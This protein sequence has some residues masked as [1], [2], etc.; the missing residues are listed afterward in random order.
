MWRCVR[1]I[2]KSAPTWIAFQHFQRQCQDDRQFLQSSDSLQDPPLARGF[3]ITHTFENMTLTAIL[4]RMLQRSL[5]FDMCRWG[6]DLMD[7]THDS[8]WVW[9]GSLLSNG[10][11]DGQLRYWLPVV[12]RWT[13]AFFKINTDCLLSTFITNYARLLGSLGVQ[14]SENK[15]SFLGHASQNADYLTCFQNLSEVIPFL[16]QTPG[17]VYSQRKGIG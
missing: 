7:D 13:G 17:Q 2:Y 5:R 12:S 1:K 9:F 6:S 8:V 16:G 4:V 3:P 11:S 15:E 14:I 10:V